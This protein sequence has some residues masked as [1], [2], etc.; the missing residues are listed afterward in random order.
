MLHFWINK[1]G[2]FYSAA[3]IKRS[4]CLDKNH[5]F[6]FHPLRR[7]CSRLKGAS[8]HRADTGQTSKGWGLFID[9]SLVLARAFQYET[10]LFRWMKIEITQLLFV[11]SML[12]RSSHLSHRMKLAK[13]RLFIYSKLE[14]KISKIY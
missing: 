1:F 8:Q 2:Q 6:Y 13:L 7:D 14:P 9:V 10:I 5:F 11:Q 4:V 12:N 3:E